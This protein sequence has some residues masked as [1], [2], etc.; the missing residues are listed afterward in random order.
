MKEGRS[1]NE[2][3]AEVQRQ[4]S[5]KRDFIAPSRQL[6]AQLQSIVETVDLEKSVS[7]AKLA[8]KHEV[9]LAIPIN[10]HGLTLPL[11]DVAHRQVQQHLGIPWT[12]YEK[13]LTEAP[14]LLTVNMNHWLQQDAGSRMVRTL[15][16]KVRAFKSDKYRRLDN[17][18]LL[19]AI[20]PL[21]PELNLV[22]QSCEVTDRRLY[23]KASRP[24]MRAEIK[25]SK[26]VG[27]IVEAGIVVSNSE[28]GEGSVVVQPLLYRLSC[29]NGAI[30]SDTSLRK[31]HTG[32]RAGSAE[33]PYELLSDETKMHQDL[34]FWG[35]VRDLTKS[36]LD[37]VVFAEGVK[38]IERSAGDVM[39]ARPEAVIEAAA[40]K[41]S[42]S[43]TE[44][45]DIFRHLVDG[46]DLSR[47]GLTNA[48]TRAS[49]DVQEYDRATDLE[50]IGG[51]VIE[52]AVQDWYAMAG[53]KAA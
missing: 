16:N 46:G 17:I 7:D 34:A 22:V 49:Q 29:T 15:D 43:Q 45:G 18:D 31:L 50:R 10:G 19:T 6:T 11:T 28:I 9:R 32:A 25:G 38:Q 8:T 23:V 33:V 36:A 21:F 13:M 2:L 14:D 24:S 42:L 39:E 20:L 41:F 4:V 26:Q 44:A 35:S 40:E 51:Q 5:T 37:G 12:Y 27:D 1:I 30:R 47:W 53:G 3:A 48:I 52:M